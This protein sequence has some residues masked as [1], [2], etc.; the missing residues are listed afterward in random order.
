MQSLNFDDGLKSFAING[1]ESRVIRFNPADPDLII[2]YDKA[3]KRIAGISTE[4]L[5]AVKLDGR[6]Q[7]LNKEDEDGYDEAVEALKEV[8]QTIREALKDL[9]IADVYDIVFAGMSPFAGAT[10]GRFV[11]E[12]FMEAV[13]PILENGISEYR[14]ASEKRMEK[15][16]KGYK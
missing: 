9:F 10:D 2:R 7:L 13:K 14:A 12:T 4:K 1:D 8:N 5:S 16:T 3:R 6:G 11:F 15:Y